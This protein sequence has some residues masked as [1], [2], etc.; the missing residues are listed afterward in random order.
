VTDKQLQTYPLDTMKTRVQNSLV[1]N[2]SKI[3]Q[4]SVA[5][6]SKFKGIEMIIMRSCIQNMLQMSLFEEIKNWINAKPFKDGTTK[7]EDYE[8]KRV[9]E[10]PPAI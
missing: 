7:L 1:G 8:K 4:E 10:K 3:A 2:V 9:V 6:S 5:R